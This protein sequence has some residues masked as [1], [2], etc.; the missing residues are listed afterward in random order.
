MPL[1][2][3]AHSSERCEHSSVNE[4]SS[5]PNG[6]RGQWPPLSGCKQNCG[7]G[8]QDLLAYKTSLTSRPGQESPVGLGTA[9]WGLP[10]T[11]LSTDHRTRWVGGQVDLR[12]S[13]RVHLS[14][15]GPGVLRSCNKQHPSDRTLR[16]QPRFSA[17]RSR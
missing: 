7:S 16:C 1:L 6:R 5:G 11:L 10:L 17:A 8:V 12:D 9:G 15:Q 3:S 4:S 13:C 2:R 14:L